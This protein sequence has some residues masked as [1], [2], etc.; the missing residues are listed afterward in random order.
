M[1]MAIEFCV[2]PVKSMRD[3]EGE[4]EHEGL[5]Q[6]ITALPCKKSPHSMEHASLTYTCAN[7]LRAGILPPLPANPRRSTQATPTSLSPINQS[8]TDEQQQ[9][10]LSRV[11]ECF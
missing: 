1:L 2:V 7:Y 6:L 3:K 11:R 5:G 8:A 4:D 10:L 9:A